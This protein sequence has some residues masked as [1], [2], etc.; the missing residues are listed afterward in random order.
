MARYTDKEFR[1]TAS[2]LR[3]EVQKLL[4]GG[5]QKS[6]EVLKKPSGPEV[7]LRVWYSRPY[8]LDDHTKV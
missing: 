3:N 4:I 6:V 1:G 5:P 8:S 7:I 2:E